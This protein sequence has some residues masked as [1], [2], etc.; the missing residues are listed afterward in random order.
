MFG[1][2][3][4]LQKTLRFDAWDLGFT[5]MDIEKQPMKNKRKEAW[6]NLAMV[7]S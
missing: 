7:A 4:V 6:G 5:S 3:Q 2:I 1:I